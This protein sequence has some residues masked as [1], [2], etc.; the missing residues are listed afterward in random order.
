MNRL[1]AFGGAACLAATA[2]SATLYSNVQQFG[3]SDVSAFNSFF[4]T[5][6]DIELT[7]NAPI[8]NVSIDVE[9]TLGDTSG[10]TML[11]YDRNGLAD[12]GTALASQSGTFTI[13][14]GQSTINFDFGGLAHASTSIWVGLEFSDTSADFY[15]VH[16]GDPQVGSSSDGWDVDLV[17]TWT[18]SDNGG[19]PPKNTYVMTIESVPEPASL[20]ALSIGGIAVAGRRRMVNRARR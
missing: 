2:Q 13:P 17:N 7:S 1:L 9:S 6:D 16:G 20:L 10:L 12:P 14:A 4:E 15:V 18:W 11:I 8:G 19:S 5:A 3:G